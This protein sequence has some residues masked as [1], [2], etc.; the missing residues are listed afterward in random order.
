MKASAKAFAVAG[1]V[2]TPIAAVL[3]VDA[4]SVDENK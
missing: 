4:S 1:E 3:H 2:S